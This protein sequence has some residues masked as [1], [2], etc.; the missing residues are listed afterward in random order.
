MTDQPTPDTTAAPDA[1]APTSPDDVTA[2]G[3]VT[4]GAY[5]LL[6]AR[7]PTTD[8]AQAAYANVRYQPE[9]AREQ[10]V[11]EGYYASR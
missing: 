5:A 3:L 1:A 8:E 11:R 9:Y 2:V 6:I 7:F 10:D 4:D